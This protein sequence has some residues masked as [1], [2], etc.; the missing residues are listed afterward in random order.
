M[1]MFGLS[2]QSSTLLRCD[3]MAG[4]GH[5]EGRNCRLVDWRLEGAHISWKRI[6]AR[7]NALEA[8]DRSMAVSMARWVVK[9]EKEK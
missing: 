1:E 3:S 9:L 6:L 8:S 7:S 4:V 2:A 5:N